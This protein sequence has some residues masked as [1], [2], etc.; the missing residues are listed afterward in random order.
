M[1]LRV[2]VVKPEVLYEV[3][4]RRDRGVRKVEHRD[5]GLR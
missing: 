4:K 3:E 5:K 1:R 2:A